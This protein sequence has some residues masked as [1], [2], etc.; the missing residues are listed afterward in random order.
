MHILHII[1]GLDD[2]GAE[3]VLY[4]LCHFDQ[5]HKHTIISLDGE[6][7][8]GT[9]LRE[10]GCE[11]HSF[12]ISKEQ[13]KFLDLI[14]IFKLIRVIKPDVV[15]TWMI[16]A[17]LIGGLLAKLAGV[18]KIFWGVHFTHLSLDESFLFKKLRSLLSSYIPYKIIYCADLSRQIQ[19]SL[20]YKKSK[21]VVINNGYNLD[22]FSPNP[23]LGKKFRSALGL[24]DDTLLIGYVGRYHPA[25]DI[26]NLIKSFF[27]LK[28][29]ISNFKV[30]IIGNNLDDENYDLKHLI[31]KNDLSENIHLL[32]TRSDIPSIMNGIDL[33]T[34]SSKYEAFPNVINEA[35]AC[36]TPCVTTDVG[37]SSKIVGKTGWVVPS[38]DSWAL[39]NALIKASREKILNKNDWYERKNA[40]RERI[41]N[42]FGISRMV[43]N[44][45]NL[46]SK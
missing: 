9:M 26:S 12:T 11:V 32:G 2:G 28:A 46:W 4:R 14:K 33:L 34:L 8:Y 19:E 27:F 10:I 45:S 21:G 20:G 18:K 24:L 16:R 44:Y 39:G 42:K 22:T 38:N 40:C 41:A 3:A 25:K 13:I 30:V 29:E 6:G 5:E 17:D 7:K 15:Q 35:M 23:S 37:D 1:S 43:E 36:G 31:K